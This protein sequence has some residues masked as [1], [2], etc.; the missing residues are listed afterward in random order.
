MHGVGSV[1]ACL[2]SGF[3]NAKPRM[4]KRWRSS[5]RVHSVM[6]KYE[7]SKKKPFWHAKFDGHAWN[8]HGVLEIIGFLDKL[9]PMSNNSDFVTVRTPHASKRKLHKWHA[10]VGC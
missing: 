2:E 6:A 4:C 9:F 3:A 10:D 5:T 1:D 8:W 7:L